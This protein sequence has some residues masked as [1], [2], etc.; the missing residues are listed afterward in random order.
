MFTTFLVLDGGQGLVGH[1]F[2]LIGVVE[3]DVVQFRPSDDGLLGFGRQA[4]PPL[5]VVDVLLDDDITPP[6][7][8]GVAA[9]VGVGRDDG[10]VDGGLTHGVGR[11][12]DE[13][14]QVS[15]VKVTKPDGLVDH[16]HR[17]P[18]QLHDL[19]LELEAQVSPLGPDVEQN[20]PRRRH[21]GVHFALD[22]P[23]RV[24]FRG[25][26]DTT[27]CQSV[28]RVAPDADRARKKSLE[29]AERHVLDEVVDA[30]Q[31]GP[32][33]LDGVRVRFDG[34]DQ[35]GRRRRQGSVDALRFN[36]YSPCHGGGGGGGVLLRG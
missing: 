2:A 35:K 30:G 19:T 10:R 36:R 34:Q 28:P 24:E 29:V 6:H 3:F 20:V 4:A 26:R 33:R 16:R 5:E 7:R 22:L 13:A 1:L 15:G 25:A 21:R 18:Q 12:V 14:Q 9:V 17:V 31:D 27:L 11:A 32:H 23:E 8:P